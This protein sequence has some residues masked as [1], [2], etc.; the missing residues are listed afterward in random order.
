MGCLLLFNIHLMSHFFY[1]AIIYISDLCKIH[2]FLAP[3]ESFVYL[4]HSTTH[5]VHN[6]FPIFLCEYL[7]LGTHI[8]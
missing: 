8:A 7:G 3:I 4:Q 1:K 5:T 2:F 6:G